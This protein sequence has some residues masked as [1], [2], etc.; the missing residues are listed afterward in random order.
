MA[1]ENPQADGL[2]RQVAGYQ[3]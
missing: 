2:A 1:K 3:E